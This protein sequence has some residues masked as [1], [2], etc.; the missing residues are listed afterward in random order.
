MLRKIICYLQ[1][2]I[3]HRQAVALLAP[4]LILQPIENGSHGR[5][6]WNESPSPRRNEYLHSVILLKLGGN[7]S[8]IF[9]T[10]NVLL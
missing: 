1:V 5:M 3:D 2:N 6:T 10:A 8:L 7:F 4:H 9:R